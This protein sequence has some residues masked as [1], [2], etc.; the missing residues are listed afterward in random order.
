MTAASVRDFRLQP[1]DL[2]L[3]HR[4]DR[5]R[6][7]FGQLDCA[8]L[9]ARQQHDRLAGAGDDATLVR[10][11]DLEVHLAAHA[12]GG[13]GLALVDHLAGEPRRVA[14][15]VEPPVLALELPQPA[16]RRPSSR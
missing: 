16:R 12:V 11:A 5:R 13:L 2:V 6:R 4:P 8:V 9:A 1:L 7:R 15:E 3:E 10:A 14:D